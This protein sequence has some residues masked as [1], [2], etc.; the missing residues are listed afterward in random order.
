MPLITVS[1]SLRRVD[2]ILSGSVHS[3]R[4]FVA[5]VTEIML[6]DESCLI[7]LAR[8]ISRMNLRYPSVVGGIVSPSWHISDRKKRLVLFCADREP[9]EHPTR[10][11]D[12]HYTA[13]SGLS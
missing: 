13:G 9:G 2:G 10:L 6:F 12:R 4:S 7:A 8:G 1:I 5:G 3:V 11:L